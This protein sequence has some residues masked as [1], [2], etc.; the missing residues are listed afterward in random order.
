VL[1]TCPE[2]DYWVHLKLAQYA[3]MLTDR[4]KKVALPDHAE[5]IQ[6][7]LNM[8]YGPNRRRVKLGSYQPEL[9]GQLPHKRPI[10]QLDG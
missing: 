6:K 5:W 1:N 7:V 10:P 4:D 3:S 2:H 9:S 8:G